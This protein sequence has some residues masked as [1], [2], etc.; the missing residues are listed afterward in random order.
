V[1][2]MVV[3]MLMIMI[4]VMVM[5]RVAGA[6]RAQVTDLSAVGLTLPP[7]RHL[8]V[9]WLVGGH[10]VDAHGPAF[11]AEDFEHVVLA[12]HQSSPWQASQV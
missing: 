8:G 12:K 3:V 2:V 11:I 5:I 9:L 7:L 4:V 10:V 6:W 1:V